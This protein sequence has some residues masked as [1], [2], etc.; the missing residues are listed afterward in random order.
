MGND[1]I[2]GNNYRTSFDDTTL[3]MT[4]LGKL[5]GVQEDNI[6]EC[7]VSSELFKEISVASGAP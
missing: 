4:V 1:D 7:E 3:R 5:R 2:P 6:F